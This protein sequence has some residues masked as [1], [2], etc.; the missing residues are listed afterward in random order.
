FPPTWPANPRAPP[1]AP[2]RWL[3]TRIIGRSAFSGSISTRTGNEDVFSDKQQ[4]PCAAENQPAFS[5]QS[6]G[7]VT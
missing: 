4:A 1:N 2:P 7:I 3:A 5:A 6:G